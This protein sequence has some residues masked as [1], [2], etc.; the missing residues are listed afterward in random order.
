M[1]A[2]G[3]P[4]HPMPACNDRCQ[5]TSSGEE[6]AIKVYPKRASARKAHSVEV[7]VLQVADRDFVPN[8]PEVIAHGEQNGYPWMVQT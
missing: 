5:R 2:T 1:F 7:D 3:M 8:V 6:F 4:V